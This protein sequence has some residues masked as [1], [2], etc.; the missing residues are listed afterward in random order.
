MNFSRVCGSGMGPPSFSTVYFTELTIPSRESVKVP[1]RSNKT[2]RI[3]RCAP[4]FDF[5]ISK[6]ILTRFLRPRKR[7]NTSAWKKP[8]R[9]STGS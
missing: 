5:V 7:R 8:Y 3:M 9:V 1:S 2:V 4:L 6:E